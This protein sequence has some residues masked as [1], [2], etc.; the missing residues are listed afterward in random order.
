MRGS[1]V[2]SASGGLDTGI[3]PAHA[4]LT[5]PAAR[6][7]RGTGDHPRACGAHADLSEYDRAKSGS[8]PRMRGSLSDRSGSFDIGGIIPAHA[9]LTKRF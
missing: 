2:E 3:I 9:G 6:H 8:S 5:D 7:G 1:Q 4:G